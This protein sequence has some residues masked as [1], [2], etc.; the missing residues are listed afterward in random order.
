M[1]YSL[2]DLA[3]RMLKDLGLVAAEEMP[4]PDDLAWAKET[5]E[6]E[7][8]LLAALNMPIWNGSAM[9]IPP[10]YLTALSRRI[11]LAIAPSFGLMDQ[12]T[13]MAAMREAERA[14]SSLSAP[15]GIRPLTLR[16]ND[17]MGR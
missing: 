3:T 10:A 16:T 6:G 15:R 1:A 17:V 12:A 4:S 8:T 7:V 9:A 11:G 14:L 5:V 2:T 13:A